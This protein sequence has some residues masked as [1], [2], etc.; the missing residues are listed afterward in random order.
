MQQLGIFQLSKSKSKSCKNIR[1]NLF[2]NFYISKSIDF[3]FKGREAAEMVIKYKLSDN[4]VETLIYIVKLSP[5][6]R[7]ALF[8]IYPTHPGKYQKLKCK[9][10]MDTKP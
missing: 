1:D 6:S 7:L 4:I 5:S 10:N 8:L 3:S 9:L 2:Y